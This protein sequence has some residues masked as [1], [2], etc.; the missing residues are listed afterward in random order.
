[1]LL[2]PFFI[3]NQP[4]FCIN[5]MEEDRQ[6]FGGRHP[7]HFQP[8]SSSQVHAYSHLDLIAPSPQVNT[9]LIHRHSKNWKQ[10]CTLAH[11]CW[12]IEFFN[13]CMA[14][15]SLQI[16]WNQLTQ[17][18]ACRY[19]TS[20][21]YY[22]AVYW[23]LCLLNYISI[24]PHSTSSVALQSNSVHW[25]YWLFHWK[26]EWI[27][28]LTGHGHPF[29]SGL[30]AFVLVAAYGSKSTKEVSSILVLQCFYL[31]WAS[32][33]PELVCKRWDKIL[34]NVSVVQ[35]WEIFCSLGT[36]IQYQ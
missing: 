18:H 33:Y 14:T 13:D 30:C 31:F 8:N 29:H 11:I 34:I 27:M 5:L 12:V 7:H 2:W 4:E 22:V 21:I 19:C 3:V 24:E 25:T 6:A 28:R 32:P 15:V 9:S 16:C 23:F 20:F 35:M 36:N 26:F 1:M 10:S 17:H